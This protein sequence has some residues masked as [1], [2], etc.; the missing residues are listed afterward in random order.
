MTLRLLVVK[1]NR[2]CIKTPA[3]IVTAQPTTQECFGIISVLRLIS[4]SFLCLTDLLVTEIICMS[5]NFDK[6]DFL[7]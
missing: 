6:H 1:F 4:F 2:L 7:L 3:A 5:S